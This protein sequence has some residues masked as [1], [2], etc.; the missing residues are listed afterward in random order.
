MEKQKEGLNLF[1]NDLTQEQKDSL[2]RIWFT[3]DYHHGHPPII[4]HANRPVSPEDHDEWLINEV[5]NKYIGKKDRVYMLGDISMAIRKE[6]EKFL[7]RLNG[8]K[9]LVKG[10]HDKNI[11]N[12]PHFIKIDSMMDFEYKQFGLNLHIVL[13]H[14][15]MMS[16]NKS[17]HG[18]WSLYG[19]V[20]G[21][22]KH[23][24]L[25]LDVGID[26]DDIAQYRPLNLLEIAEWMKRKQDLIQSANL[27]RIN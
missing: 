22:L 26:S 9:S 15:P 4:R 25:G 16:W 23:P 11:H 5:H 17:Y 8:Q 6:A 10:N 21:R 1:D 24:Y 7:G 13:C 12:S 18:S 27:E 2:S 14:Y 19:H 3:A 20:H